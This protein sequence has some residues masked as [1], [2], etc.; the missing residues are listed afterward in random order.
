MRETANNALYG[1]INSTFAHE[2]PLLEQVRHAGE[3]LVEGMQISPS[4]GK[5]LHVLAKLIGAK[6]VLEI[7]TFVGYSSLWIADA[8][9]E[10]GTVTTLEFNAE[11]AAL[12]KKH[13]DASEYPERFTI[14]EGKALESLEALRQ[15]NCQ[16]DLVFIDA[17]KSEYADYLALATPML[18]SGGLMI[19]D[20]TLLFGN[21]I[22]VPQ[23]QVSE[24]A[25]VA[26]RR[27]NQVIGDDDIFSGIMLPTEEGLTIG[28]KI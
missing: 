7:G 13:F 15:K 25:K 18:R 21:M 6:H 1:Y 11:N 26:M 16:Y 27:F 4:E 22:D 2:S 9:P 23:K 3:V 10:D 20:N 28:R 14:M 17:A 5:T 24:S 19:G 8:L 12:A